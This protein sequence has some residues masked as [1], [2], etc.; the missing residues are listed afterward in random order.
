MPYM[1][2]PSAPGS[3]ARALLAI[4]ALVLL[5]A[6]C[7]KKAELPD[8]KV[9]QQVERQTEGVVAVA[10]TL[11]DNKSHVTLCSGALVAPNLVLT[12]R[13]CVSR[14]VTATPSC[15]AQGRSHNGLHLAED[16][17]PAQIAVYTGRHVRP[18]M[19][20][21]QAHAVKT[22]HPV[23]QVLCDADVAFLVL[24]RPL[25]N[26]VVLP[27]RLH[28]SV[29]PGDMV[30]PVGF[31]GGRANQV[32]LRV[33]REWST[34]LAKGPTSNADTGAVLGPREFEVD[35]ATCRGDSGGPAMDLR[36]GEVVGVVS[37]GGSCT[38]QGNHVYTRV[39]AYANLAQ[40]AFAAAERAQTQRI[41]S[42]DIVNPDEPQRH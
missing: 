8:P 15:D 28:A 16:A 2:G 32:G 23:G 35:S 40:A 27:M 6:G 13:H 29:E 42:R 21:P 1:T 18:D 17:D 11:E 4:A 25:T 9:I 26:L 12:A 36:T 20:T 30:V 5:G 19:D 31:G 37:R 7:V 10:T 34:V 38:A 14:A 22:L 24:D 33:A 41:A 39:D 3:S